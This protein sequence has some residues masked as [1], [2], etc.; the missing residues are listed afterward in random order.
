MITS[1]YAIFDNKGTYYKPIFYAPTTAAAI[2]SFKLHASNPQSEYAMFPGDFNL[3]YMGTW[4]DETGKF[5]QLENPQ[6]LGTLSS[7][8][9][10]S[11][12]K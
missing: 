1:V 2:R 3:N 6:N 9:N 5:E 10:T 11:E 4:N 8:L 12:E 7:Y